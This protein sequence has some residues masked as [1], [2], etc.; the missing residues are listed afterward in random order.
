MLIVFLSFLSLTYGKVNYHPLDPLTPLELTQVQSIVKNS[1]CSPCKNLSFHYVGLDEPDKSI[2]LSWI[3][4]SN[5]KKN[6]PRQASVIARI[7]GRSHEIIVNL[8]DSEVI[9]D[10]IYN[11]HGFPMLN[12]EEQEAA[13]KL[14]LSY[15]P[16]IVSIEKRGLKLEEILCQSFTIGWYGE[17][18]TSRVVKVMC[19]Y[20]DGTINFY[21]RPIEAITV[22]VDLDQMKI[23]GYKDRLIVPVPKGDGVDYRESEQ[24]YSSGPSLN[25]INI[26]QP[27]GPSFTI[28]GHTVRWADWEFH[29]AFDMRVATIISLASIY[30]LETDEHRRVLYR[31]FASELFVPYMDLTEE[32][33]YRTFID[34]GEYGFGLCTVPLQPLRDCPQ[35]AV[36]LDGYLVAND[37][38]PIKYANVFCIFERYA[39]DVLWRH[40]ELGIPGKTY[41]EVRPEV[42]L[43]VRMVTAVGNYD[44]I[45]DWEFKQTGIVKVNVGLS[46]L[47]EVR[48][49]AYTYKDQI[50][51][52]VYGTLLAENTLGA[53]HDHFCTF[54]L[55]LDVDGTDNS[56][57]KNNMKTRRVMDG[58]SPRRSYWTVVSETAKTESDARVRLG[59]ISADLLVVNPNKRTKMG[60][61]VGYRLI[62]GSVTGPLLSDDDYPQTRAAFT[63]YNLWVT[64]YN[65]SEKWAG[66]TFADQSQGDDD[67]AVWS[68]RNR[69][70]E[71]KDI[72][73]WYTL[74]IH[75]IPYQ[76]DFPI[77]PTI[78]T[79][80]ELRPANFFEHNPTLKVPTT[81]QVKHVNCSGRMGA[82][83]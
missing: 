46:G 43:V 6:P 2:V 15:P 41:T 68:L 80:F 27:D 33:Y 20:L 60:N 45:V 74:G 57:V 52:E 14:P 28:D 64:P 67:L 11:G 81:M 78:G 76:E 75:H 77:M 19:Y 17:K 7:D 16:F 71:N 8:E 29:V 73:L 47:L 1:L 37:G 34:E 51:E 65:K 59:S 50:Q 62:P 3:S 39:G 42:S 10:K 22:T 55:D 82:L 56:F 53:Y 66:G 70:I 83:S 5:P 26:L 49:S 61:Q 30:D 54:H 44:Y 72:V 31:G 63:K 32:W 9:S 24:N 23:I 35:N 38:T 36:F 58:R 18:S 12:A 40:T 25:R 13:N 48:G 69:D 79:G 4:Q 21:M